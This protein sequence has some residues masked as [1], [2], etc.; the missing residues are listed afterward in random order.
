M[1][2]LTKNFKGKTIEDIKDYTYANDES[3]LA[4]HFTDGTATVYKFTTGLGYDNDRDFNIW[5]LTVEGSYGYFEY[6]DG[7]TR[8]YVAHGLGLMTESEYQI[9]DA[10][11]KAKHDEQ[12]KAWRKKHYDELKK[13][14]EQ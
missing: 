4:I 9:E 11:Y 12:S 14:F 5:G 10:K 7:S 6:T 8:Y 13:E 1:K 3:Y 2:P